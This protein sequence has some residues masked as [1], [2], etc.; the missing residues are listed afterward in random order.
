MST[1]QRHQPIGFVCCHCQYRSSGS[2]CS[3]PDR[4][5][6]PH[7][8][9]PRCQQCA[10]I[11]I[12]SGASDE[13]NAVAGET[14]QESTPGQERQQSFGSDTSRGSL[15]EELRLASSAERIKDEK[16]WI[17]RQGLNDTGGST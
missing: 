1:T 3:N 5:D 15:Y 9:V 8:E 16:E 11:F 14:K 17:P 4:L 2:L 6:C 12:S 10:I 13:S 7:R